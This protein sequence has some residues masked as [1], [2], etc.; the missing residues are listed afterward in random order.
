MPF[1]SAAD[2]LDVMDAG[3]TIP[4]AWRDPGCP[5]DG[6]GVLYLQFALRVAD[7]LQYRA[8]VCVPRG[9]ATPKMTSRRAAFGQACVAPLGNAGGQLRK[10]SRP[11]IPSRNK[12]IQTGLWGRGSDPRQPDGG[13]PGRNDWFGQMSGPARK[14]VKRW[15]KAHLL[16]PNAV[17]SEQAGPLAE[18]FRQSAQNAGIAAAELADEI[19]D[20]ETFVA[21]AIGQM[22]R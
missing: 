14:F 15:M 16:P 8:G 20:I 4:L 1:E 12:V 19:G 7:A 11:V 9:G 6:R 2:G 18:R 22:Q 13:R 17:V 21:M 10:R 3:R 5:P